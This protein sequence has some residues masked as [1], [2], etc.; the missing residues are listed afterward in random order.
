MQIG[1][2][3]AAAAGDQDLLADSFRALQ[4]KHMPAALARLDSAHEAGSP[5]AE[6]DDIKF[7]GSRQEA[8]LLSGAVAAVACADE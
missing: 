2:I 1:E 7:L 3:A 6:H 5:A 8:V 4:H